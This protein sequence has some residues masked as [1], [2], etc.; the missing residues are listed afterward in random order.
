MKINIYPYNFDIDFTKVNVQTLVIK[1]HK[2]YSKFIY[3]LLNILNG[4]ESEEII[5]ISKNDK[6]VPMAKNVLLISDSFY[7]ITSNKKILT[8]LYSK[9]EMIINDDVEIKHEIED[10]YFTLLRKIQPFL[11]E[12]NFNLEYDDSIS[13]PI[14]FKLIS[15]KIEETPQ[16]F[17]ENILNI[18]EINNEFKL[19]PVLIFTN[20]KY[21]LNEE[22]YSEIEKYCNSKNQYLLFIEHYDYNDYKDFKIIIDHDF[23]DYVIDNH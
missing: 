5:R 17:Y 1:D 4:I 16:S 6:I 12:Y 22:E 18:I 7:D 14:L 2:Y 20:M 19:Y 9:L 8:S 13:L 3:G 23:E 10:A 21:L 11:F 15:L